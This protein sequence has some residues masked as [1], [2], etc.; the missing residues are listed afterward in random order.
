[1][2]KVLAEIGYDFPVATGVTGGEGV[3]RVSIS[4]CVAPIASRVIRDLSSSGYGTSI[5]HAT[6]FDL[7]KLHCHRM[8]EQI[9]TPPKPSA[10]QGLSTQQSQL[11]GQL[12]GYRRWSNSREVMQPSS[13][14]PA[15][16]KVREG[17]VCAHVYMH[18][19]HTW[20][21]THICEHPEPMHKS[22]LS[23]NIL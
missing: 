1:M 19:N 11:V 18:V 12:S 15:P 10:S 2:A 20:T 6:P 9:P 14:L 7:L 22:I 16:L 3:T 4:L 17:C 23:K 5:S 8:S 21:D 13:L